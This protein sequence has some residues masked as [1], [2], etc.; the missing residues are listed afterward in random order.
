M[1][2]LTVSELASIRVFL[3]NFS[4]SFTDEQLQTYAANAYTLNAE[5]YLDG[6]VAIAFYGLMTGAV[7][8]TDF[9]QGESKENQKVVY[10]R[11]AKLF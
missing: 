1:P 11:I 3:G 9:T 7:M 10:D 6:V 8:M 5:T 2:T 4:G